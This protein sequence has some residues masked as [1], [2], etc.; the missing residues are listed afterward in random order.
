MCGIDRTLESASHRCGLVQ[1]VYFTLRK[2]KKRVLYQTIL[3]LY[4]LK[5]LEIGLLIFSKGEVKVTLTRPFQ[6]LDKVPLTNS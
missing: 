5:L 3:D 4:N 6:L 2:G 1:Y